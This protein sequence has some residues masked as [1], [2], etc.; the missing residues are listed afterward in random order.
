MPDKTARGEKHYL[1]ELKELVSEAKEPRE[2]VLAVFC[3]RHGVSMEKC[4][5]YYQKL[6][7]TGEIKEE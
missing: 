6:V 3:H 1:T 7:D 5:V 2:K 4:R